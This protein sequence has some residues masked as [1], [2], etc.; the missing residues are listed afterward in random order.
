M[1]HLL[2]V[3][4]NHKDVQ[5]AV[6]GAVLGSLGINFCTGLFDNP[7]PNLALLN[8]TLSSPRHLDIA[9]QMSHEAI[10]MLNKDGFLL[11]TP[12]RAAVI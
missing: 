10:V 11:R 9:C 2:D 8:K 6:D 12:E 5:R 4:Q 3:I 7:L 1:P